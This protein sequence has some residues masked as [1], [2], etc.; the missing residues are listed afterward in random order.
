[1]I[2]RQ[3]AKLEADIGRNKGI[4]LHEHDKDIGAEIHQ[5]HHYTAGAATQLKGSSIKTTTSG[6]AFAI[7]KGEPS[8]RDT[9]HD[10]QGPY[11]NPIL[12]E[13]APEEKPYSEHHMQQS[14]E[15]PPSKLASPQCTSAEVVTTTT[16]PPQQ[17][18][19]VV[20]LVCRRQR[21]PP[22]N[23]SAML[24][25]LMVTDNRYVLRQRVSLCQRRL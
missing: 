24:L 4:Y 13:A 6:C 10:G 18:L 9:T 23:P 8:T 20:E 19:N 15:R 12:M 1:M 3:L 7:K 17:N 22:L 16:S 11:H 25:R 2:R 14:L 5:W 21:L